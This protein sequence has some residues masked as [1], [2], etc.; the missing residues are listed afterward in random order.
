MCSVKFKKKS[1]NQEKEKKFLFRNNSHAR[2]IFWMVYEFNV[3]E[4]RIF[5]LL[6]SGIDLTE[7]QIELSLRQASLSSLESSSSSR[8][9]KASTSRLRVY[10]VL[11]VFL[12]LMHGYSKALHHLWDN[13]SKKN[14][15]EKNYNPKYQFTWPFFDLIT[16]ALQIWTRDLFEFSAMTT[17]N[18]AACLPI[19]WNPL[20]NP[21]SNPARRPNAC[22]SSH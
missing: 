9:R 19:N 20:A 5:K 1:R 4:P 22:H 11:A 18:P 8:S 10:F 7:S 2:V 14:I 6:F 21:Q 16:L 3:N 12:L 15:W 17:A 13:F